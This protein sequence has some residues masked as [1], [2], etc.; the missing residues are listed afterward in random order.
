MSGRVH[1][2]AAAVNDVNDIVDF[3]AAENLD[4]A[5]RFVD[6]LEATFGQLVQSPELGAVHAF[7]DPQL[8][9]IRIWSPSR[10]RNYLIFYRPIQHE[11]LVIRV[12]HAA[13]DWEELIGSGEESS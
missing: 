3:L 2:T 6:S 7:S 8:A 11:I 5:I 10:F 13:R 12:I 4:L 1:R 9:N